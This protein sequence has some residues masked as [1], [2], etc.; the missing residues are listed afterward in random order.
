MIFEIGSTLTKHPSF[1]SQD[2]VKAFQSLLDLGIRLR[3]FVEPKLLGETYEISK[4]L[5]VTFYDASY[6]AL[7]KERDAALVTAD[8]VL[9]G[10]IKRYCKAQLLSDTTSSELNT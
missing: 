5:Q 4:Q 9:Y 2:S 6:V 3:S 8:R 1:T 7:A 10:K